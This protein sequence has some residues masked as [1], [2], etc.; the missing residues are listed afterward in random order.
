[1]SVGKGPEQEIALEAGGWCRAHLPAPLRPQ[2]FQAEVA[3]ARDLSLD[4]HQIGCPPWR[5]QLPLHH[6]D[7]A[8]RL[9]AA[10]FGGVLP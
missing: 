10:R 6:H 3:H 4:P 7:P 2:L 9:T 1:M 5:S 8:S